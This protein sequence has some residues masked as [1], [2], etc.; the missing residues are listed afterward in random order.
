M[1]PDR[2]VWLWLTHHLLLD[3]WGTSLLSLRAAELYEAL[4][5]GGKPGPAGFTH[6]GQLAAATDDP[7]PDE[8]W[9]RSPDP[10]ASIALR[11]ENGGRRGP[12]ILG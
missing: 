9:A 10:F 7:L 12:A 11:T 2:L 3:A 6:P 1:G 8:F 4:A 5:A